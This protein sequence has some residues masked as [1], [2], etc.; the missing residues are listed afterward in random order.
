MEREWITAYCGEGRGKTAAALG[1]G[2]LAADKGKSVI[3]IQF[4]KGRQERELKVISRM[5]PELKVFRFEKFP[6]Q[7]NEL[8]PEEQAEETVNI[9]NAFNFAKKVL[10]T[11]GCDLL[12]LDEILGLLDLD[13]ITME[14]MKC[15]LDAKADA[16]GLV[17]TGIHMKEELVPYMDK[18]YQLDPIKE[19]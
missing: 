15:L 4:L 13:L 2:V 12:V 3:V 16:T 9:R 7:F 17:V 5:E 11:E 1:Q 6:R 14:D 19:S 8:T 18:V 10:V